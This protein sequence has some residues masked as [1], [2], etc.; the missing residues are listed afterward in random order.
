MRL[1][2]DCKSIGNISPILQ[3]TLPILD[4]R[5]KFDNM[6]F[7]RSAEWK[8][9]FPGTIKA[10]NFEQISENLKRTL[11]NILKTQ[12][13]R[14]EKSELVTLQEREAELGGLGFDSYN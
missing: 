12:Y 3:P 8:G 7:V 1:L 6:H 2:G 5:K 11:S 4:L 14:K 13:E 9:Y 10:G